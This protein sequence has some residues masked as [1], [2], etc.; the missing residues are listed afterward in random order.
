MS[1][2]PSGAAVLRPEKT[3]AVVAAVLEVLGERGWDGLSM[4]EVASRAGV[5]KPALYR[6]WPSKD[7]MVLD[8]VVAAGR[9]VALPGDTGQLRTDLLGFLAPALA[10]LADPRL[11]RIIAAVL[12]A[13]STRPE[14]A[15]ALDEAFRAPRR[16]AAAR[17]FERA[18]ARGEVPP[19]TDVPLATDLLAGPLYML[20]VGAEDRR[21]TS[22]YAER[23]VDAVLRQCFGLPSSRAQAG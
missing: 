17:A 19:D 13:T 3:A 22:G 2:P 5:G 23:L 6:R 11:S 10:A 14:L 15:R 8:V 7:A 12:A 9:D 21:V 16:Q 4:A 18:I 1:R 20:A